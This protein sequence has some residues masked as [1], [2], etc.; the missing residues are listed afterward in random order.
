MRVTVVHV[1]PWLVFKSVYRGRMVCLDECFKY[2]K[3]EITV[4]REFIFFYLDD[5]YFFH[6]NC[7]Y[8]IPMRTGFFP[9][10]ATPFVLFI[11]NQA[12]IDTYTHD[13]G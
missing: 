5:V 11:Q 9:S 7:A 4:N 13:H 6:V 8:L 2:S 3:Q 10:G 12:F 1:L